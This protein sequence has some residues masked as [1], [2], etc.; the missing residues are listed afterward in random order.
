MTSTQFSGRTAI[1]TGGSRGIGLAI[2]QRLAADGANVVLTSRKQE[3]ADAAAEQVDG[4]A[5]GVAA[6]ATDEDAARR[7]VELTLDRFGGI[8][9]LVNNAGTNPAYGPLIEQDHARFAKTF[10]V[11]LWAPLLWTSLAVKAWM[12]EHGGAVVN[13]ASIGGMHQSPQMGMYNATKAA[14]IHVTKQLALELSPKVRV[15]AICPG[16][17]R[18]KLAEALWK[19]HEDAV[20]GVTALGRIGEPPDVAAAVAFLVSDEASWITGE[21][22]VID[23]G[24]LLGN[25][26][27]F[28]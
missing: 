27:G 6:H 9:I 5:I 21:T 14:L 4:N 15:N 13:T 10:E 11:N 19:D 20:S 12:A 1:V 24:Q 7:C 26:A 28:R 3:S 2:A 8:D 16:V 17:V 18:T 23:G 25:A 22:M